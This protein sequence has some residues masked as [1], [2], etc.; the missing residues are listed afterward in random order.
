MAF[1]TLHA[2]VIEVDKKR[3]LRNCD[4][5]VAR[6]YS[7]NASFSRKQAEVLRQ[8]LV[9][10]ITSQRYA[11]SYEAYRGEKYVE[12]KSKY[13]RGTGKS[14][15]WILYGDLIKAIQLRMIKWRGKSH[16][17]VGIPPGVFDSGGK[18]WFGKG[19]KGE[20]KEII[21]YAIW[22]EKGRAGQPARPLFE[23]TQDEFAVSD[24]RHRMLAQAAIRVAWGWR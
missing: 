5:L 13:G 11:P 20:A 15:F 9:G 21:K 6:L 18:S 14:D 4:S 24:L 22:M 19:D 16:L 8:R 17:F 1:F 2:E 3:F 7:N 12:W 10:N 23:P